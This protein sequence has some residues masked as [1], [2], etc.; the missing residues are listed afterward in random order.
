MPNVD[1]FDDRPDPVNE[2]KHAS[3]V[4]QMTLLSILKYL[5]DTYGNRL[6][7]LDGNHIPSTVLDDDMV[8]YIGP[9]DAKLRYVD[10]HCSFYFTYTLYSN[11]TTDDSLAS[12]MKQTKHT[13]TLKDHV[14]QDLLSKITPEECVVL[15]RISYEQL[16]DRYAEKPKSVRRKI[17]QAA[18]TARTLVASGTLPQSLSE[19]KKTEEREEVTFEESQRTKE[20]FA[21]ALVAEDEQLA[22][23]LPDVLLQ[24]SALLAKSLDVDFDAEETDDHKH[25]ISKI[26]FFFEAV[27]NANVQKTFGDYVDTVSRTVRVDSTIVERALG[28]LDHETRKKIANIIL[29]LGKN[30]AE[31][32]LI[33]RTPDHAEAVR[34]GA[35]KIA[36]SVA[37]GPELKTTA[38]ERV[39]ILPDCDI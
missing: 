5:Q 12:H 36:K 31:S 19:W 11:A 9:I 10:G 35:E 38:K 13:Y 4:Y 29:F 3:D 21:Q 7:F 1:S 16:T 17:Q 28:R 24:D 18:K 14:T 15:A 22:W 25:I 6:D 32:M 39:M 33:Q 34:H 37:D 20:K 8:Q 27:F 30:S 26:R 2:S 23:A